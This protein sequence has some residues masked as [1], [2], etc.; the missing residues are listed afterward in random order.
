[1]RLKENKFSKTL[2]IV[3]LY[4]ALGILVLGGLY[5]LI[6]AIFENA[7][8]KEIIEK[9]FLFHLLLSFGLFC[10]FLFE[11][12]KTANK[13]AEHIEDL[14]E[15]SE[16]FEELYNKLQEECLKDIER[17]RKI[18]CFRKI[19]EKILQIGIA[20][21][22]VLY[23]ALF[24]F[25]NS[26]MNIFAPITALVIFIYILNYK[27]NKKYEEK[28]E[29][30]Y[31]ECVINS[32]IKNIGYERLKFIPKESGSEPIFDELYKIL[33]QSPRE[34]R[35]DYKNYIEGLIYNDLEMKFTDMYLSKAKRKYIIPK[36]YFTGY[37]GF[38]EFRRILFNG[39]SITKKDTYKQKELIR[40]TNNEVF[41]KYF[42]LKSNNERFKA[43]I[44]RDGITDAVVRFYLSTNMDLEILTRGE[45]IIFKI[46]SGS[47]FEPSLSK[48]YKEKIYTQYY[49]L[50][51]IFILIEDIYEII[52]N[53]GY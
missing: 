27:S 10:V 36:V 19:I 47:I 9:I 34:E 49:F 29:S 17:T 2:T 43:G 50:N 11:V 35:S 32:I 53:N 13:R 8:I 20:V 12:Y 31:K 22:I 18:L 1:M 33:Y 41:D 52:K 24:V 14:N 5:C 25:V 48:N 4:C 38:L 3:M 44:I 42:I 28:F 46:F 45:K 6:F 40:E 16:D 23:T 30:K 7:V 39:F 21:S 15:E 26:Y 51:E 37:F